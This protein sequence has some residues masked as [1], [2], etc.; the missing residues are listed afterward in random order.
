M[1]NQKQELVDLLETKI[2]LRQVLVSDPVRKEY[3][4]LY[5][6]IETYFTALGKEKFEEGKKLAVADLSGL[7]SALKNPDQRDRQVRLLLQK[8]NTPEE[9]DLL[10]QFMQNL[11]SLYK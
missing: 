8:Y 11:I 2:T 3:P 9:R 10:L 7:L 6:D 5:E 1:T 4:D